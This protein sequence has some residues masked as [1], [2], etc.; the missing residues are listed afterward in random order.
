MVVCTCMATYIGKNC[1]ESQHL[2][3]IQPMTQ[4][5]NLISYNKKVH[6]LLSALHP[7]VMEYNIFC[8]IV[9]TITSLPTHPY[10]ALISSQK[11]LYTKT[12]TLAIKP[13]KAPS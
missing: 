11:S 6:H 1:H 9:P 5:D 12:V 4:H 2:I 8:I 10:F 13:T 3:V 7:V